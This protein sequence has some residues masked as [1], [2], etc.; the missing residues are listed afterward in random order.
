MKQ[1]SKE[2]SLL[3]EWLR[4]EGIRNEI[5]D[6]ISLLNYE[7]SKLTEESNS[8]GKE[9]SKYLKQMSKTNVEIKEV[10][11]KLIKSTLG[12]LVN[13]DP[14]ASDTIFKQMI[15]SKKQLLKLNVDKD[16]IEQLCD[17]NFLR[18]GD[19]DI[20]LYKNEMDI[21]KLKL[22]VLLLN[23]KQFLLKRKLVSL[24]GEQ[25]FDESVKQYSKQKI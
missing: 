20:L 21:S 19:I 16:R 7:I 17:N 25:H 13:E 18:N 22:L 5:N 1:I 9:H 3:K 14:E 23:I 24:L 6:E 4:L 8:N 2:N 11:F 10:K 15:I 12:Y